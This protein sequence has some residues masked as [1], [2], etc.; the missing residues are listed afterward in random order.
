MISSLLYILPELKPRSG[1]MSSL[2]FG[3][4]IGG[5]V[6]NL[7]VIPV[8]E[9]DRLSWGTRTIWPVLPSRPTALH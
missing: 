9:D 8:V 1:V 3:R 2:L 5:Q 7:Q 6:D 4:K